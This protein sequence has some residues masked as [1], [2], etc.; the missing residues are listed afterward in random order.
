MIKLWDLQD[1]VHIWN[2]CGITYGLC[3]GEYNNNNNYYYKFGMGYFIYGLWDCVH[4]VP[5]YCF[6]FFCHGI[7][8]YVFRTVP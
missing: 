1:T 4:S 3:V 5:F 2:W 6:F 8:M 7:A